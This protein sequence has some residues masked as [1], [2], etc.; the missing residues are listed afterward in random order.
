MASVRVHVNRYKH[1]NFMINLYSV[2]DDAVL[3]LVPYLY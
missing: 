3:Y 2:D 1:G